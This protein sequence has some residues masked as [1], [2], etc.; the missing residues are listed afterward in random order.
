MQTDCSA[1][2]QTRTRQA[3][4]A[5]QAT[6]GLEA[7]GYLT[8][9]QADTLIALGQEAVEARRVEEAQ[10]ADDRAYA[11]AQR[12]DTAAA[13]DGYLAAYPQG[14]HAG[15]ARQAA[16][17]AAE[18]EAQEEATRQARV[19]GRCS[20]RRS[21]TGSIR[22]QRTQTTYEH[23]PEGQH[24]QVGA[25]PPRRR[26]KRPTAGRRRQRRQAQADDAVYAAAE[27]AD[28]AGRG[29]KSIYLAAYPQGRHVAEARQRE[30]RQRQWRVQDSPFRDS[31]PNGLE[32]KGRRWS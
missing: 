28:T 9:D 23:I 4:R 2:Q 6:K 12:A 5:W 11:E 29:M 17:V 32:G 31:L 8:Q 1:A 16:Q 26:F 19:G 3:I 21:T 15:A 20:L 24:V 22:R 30:Q 18:R 7:S 14:Q 25:S 10:A 27:R 13:Y